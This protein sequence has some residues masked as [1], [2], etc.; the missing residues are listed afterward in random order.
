MTPTLPVEAFDPPLAYEQECLSRC[1][2]H[3]RR[4][5]FAMCEFQP[6]KPNQY[7]YCRF[8]ELDN[9]LYA[10]ISIEPAQ[11]DLQPGTVCWKIDGSKVWIIL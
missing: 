2:A 11:P 4:L 5:P 10:N 8:I 7:G 9:K 1:L 6:Q 3:R